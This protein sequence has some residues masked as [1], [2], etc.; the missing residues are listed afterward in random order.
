MNSEQKKE[1][2]MTDTPQFYNGETTDQSPKKSSRTSRAIYRLPKE[3]KNGHPITIAVECVEGG[4]NVPRNAASFRQ[5]TRDFE[6]DMETEIES[7]AAMAETVLNAL[8]VLQPGE[9]EIEFGIELGG[10]M[11]IP[12]ITKG[13]AKGN[14][15]VTLKWNKS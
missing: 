2:S 6:I 14:F 11:G 5:L 8:R 15:K 9:V 4:G 3:D 10:E 13:E 1:S 12:L 7:V